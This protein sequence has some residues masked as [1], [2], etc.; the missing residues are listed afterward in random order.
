MKR[1]KIVKEKSVEVYGI[2]LN[3]GYTNDKAMTECPDCKSRAIKKVGFGRLFV[4]KEHLGVNL[5]K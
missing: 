4:I 5:W 1:K 2:C 3:C